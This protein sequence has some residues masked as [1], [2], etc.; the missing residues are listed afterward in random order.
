MNI[1]EKANN[2]Q[3]LRKAQYHIQSSYWYFGGYKKDVQRQEIHVRI[4]SYDANL[5][6]TEKSLALLKQEKWLALNLNARNTG[7][8]LQWKK[9][10]QPGSVWGERCTRVQRTALLR[11]QTVEVCQ[12]CAGKERRHMHLWHV[13]EIQQAWA[14]K[15]KDDSRGMAYKDPTF[16]G[17][18][19]HSICMTLETDETYGVGVGERWWIWSPQRWEG[20]GVKNEGEEGVQLISVLSKDGPHGNTERKVNAPESH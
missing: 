7:G 11:E 19:I 10:T 6:P 9:I 8:C 3:S 15:Q 18:E 20:A 2:D 16:P 12:V 14:Q 4:K 17:K 1:S 5:G 13:G